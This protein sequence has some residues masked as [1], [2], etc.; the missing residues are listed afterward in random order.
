L[1]ILS[2]PIA[3]RGCEHGPVSRPSLFLILLAALVLLIKC[4]ICS[5]LEGMVHKHCPTK[6]LARRHRAVELGYIKP[7]DASMY[8]AAEVSIAP[9]VKAAAKSLSLHIGHDAI[10]GTCSHFARSAT[11]A[12]QS[13]GAICADEAKIAISAHRI[14]NRAKHGISKSRVKVV[15]SSSCVST[16]ASS[17]DDPLVCCK[18]VRWADAT[19]VPDA[20]YDS[21]SEIDD[22][23]G[24][25]PPP[26]PPILNSCS[27]TSRFGARC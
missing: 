10:A 13:Q 24:L 5:Y 12:A 27:T 19:S 3:R 22:W 4:D 8:V 7:K 21:E 25:R 14:A 15:R 26:P 23:T 16:S 9:A 18:K 17:G 6:L 1:Y 20:W 11:H 2:I